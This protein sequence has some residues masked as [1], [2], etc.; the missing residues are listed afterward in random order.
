MAGVTGPAE[1]RDA[2]REPL[3][4]LERPPRWD[5]TGGPTSGRRGGAA[6]HP[7]IPRIGIADPGDCS[8]GGADIVNHTIDSRIGP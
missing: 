2:P 5:D 3:T 1:W 6:V 4:C 8:V 7:N